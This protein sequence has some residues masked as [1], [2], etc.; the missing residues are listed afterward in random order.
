MVSAA[1]EPFS[2]RLTFDRAT[3]AELCR[4]SRP[5]WSWRRLLGRLVMVVVVLGGFVAY[6][7]GVALWF[8]RNTLFF[9]QNT[10]EG[11]G[12]GDGF[13]GLLGD[14]FRNG[15]PFAAVLAL[16]WG[17]LLVSLIGLRI[18]SI[19]TVRMAHAAAR[20]RG[21]LLDEARVEVGPDGVLV[22]GEGLE[23]RY[24]WSLCERAVA[25]KQAVW[26]FFVA[27][28]LPLTYAGLE[29]EADD[30]LRRIEAF[31]AASAEDGSDQSASGGETMG[32]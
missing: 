27:G 14:F 8:E 21:R 28:G 6:A 22:R 15:D 18:A 7:V 16:V 20:E 11:G 31:R 29:I 12:I 23:T 1:A 4:L 30:A 32:A 13:D 3:Y 25:G 10:A 9:L 17:T 24:G 26:I 2:A 19:P 5:P